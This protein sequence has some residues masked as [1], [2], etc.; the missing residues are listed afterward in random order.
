[1]SPGRL[2]RGTRAGA[3][4]GHVRRGFTLIELLVV[5]AVIAVLIGILFPALRGA[6]QAARATRENVAGRTLMEGYIA[7]AMDHKDQLI[8]GHMDEAPDLTDDMGN[9]LSPPEVVK[10]WPWRLMAYLSAGPRGSVLV[11]EREQG[12]ADRGQPLWSYMVSLTP[13][14]G[15]NYFNLGGDLTSGG[16]SNMPGWLRRMDGAVTPARMLVFCSSRSLLN[17]GVVQ[18]YFKIVPPTKSFEYSASGWTGAAFAESGDPAAW[19]YVHPRWDGKAAA[20]MLDGHAEMLGIDG[21]RDMRRW[22]NEA[23]RVGDSV[24]TGR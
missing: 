23:S 4:D 3:K 17:T 14:L 9:T 7:Y 13:S 5:I 6:R 12:L 21:L 16:V 15:L 22:S 11:G 20:S 19:G 10:R 24:W 18:G 8:P 1:M 2:T